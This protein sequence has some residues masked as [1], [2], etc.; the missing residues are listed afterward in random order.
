MYPLNNY[1]VD[2]FQKDLC[3]N[4]CFDLVPFFADKENRVSGH[5]EY[6]ETWEG[7]MKSKDLIDIPNQCKFCRTI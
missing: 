1:I 3:C 5:S 2:K 7:A 4:Q 6:A